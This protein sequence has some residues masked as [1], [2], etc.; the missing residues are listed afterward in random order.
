M[1]KLLEIKSKIEKISGSDFV[2]VSSDWKD[3][4]GFVDDLKDGIQQLGLYIIDDPLHE[5]SDSY[6]VLI[7]KTPITEE[8]LKKYKEEIWGE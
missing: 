8:D 2:S 1:K 3:I 7:S 4:E 6:G 5:G